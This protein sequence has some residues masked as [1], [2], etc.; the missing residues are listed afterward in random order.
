MSRDLF[1]EGRDQGRLEVLE[2][3][4]SLSKGQGALW[5]FP[6]GDYVFDPNEYHESEK[7]D[8]M[9]I[10]PTK[11]VSWLKKKNLIKETTSDE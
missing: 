5:Y 2:A 10:E 11:M 8:Y 6:S 4:L 7:A 9:C 1:E 3:M